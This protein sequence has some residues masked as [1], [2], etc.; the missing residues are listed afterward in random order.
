MNILI[1][2]SGALATLF[3]ARL[4]RAGHQI[5]VLGSWPAGLSS[6]RTNGAVLID[7]NGIEQTFKLRVCDDPR[8]ALGAKYAIVLVKSWQTERAARELHACLAQDGIALTLQNGYGNREILAERLGEARVGLGTT[9][10]G[11]TLMGPGR[12]REGGE[13]VISL[14]IHPGL[15]PI[16]QALRGANFKVE[17]VEDAGSLVWGKLVIN[18]AINPLT[19]LLG[20]PNGELLNYPA[21]RDLMRALA[22]E[23]AAVA[24]KENIILPF[25]DPGTAVEEVV[26]KTAANYSSMLQDIRRGAP[27]EID[28]ICGAVTRI[29]QQYNVSTPLNETCW[30]LVQALVEISKNSTK[31]EQ[32]NAIEERISDFLKRL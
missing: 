25:D 12:V 26:R 13:G 7:A 14:Q 32:T 1:V 28:A 9:T 15:E 3:A 20:V 22:E 18:A 10:T 16:E 31:T 8:D 21:T 30:R 5:T 24:S 19:A 23:V 27:T 11:A 4:T 6:L 17:L 29:G 2:G